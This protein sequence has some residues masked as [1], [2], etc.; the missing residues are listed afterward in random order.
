MAAL[1][2]MKSLTGQFALLKGKTE[3]PKNLIPSLCPFQKDTCGREFEL[4]HELAYANYLFIPSRSFFVNQLF[5]RIIL[6]R[7][8]SRY[9]CFPDTG[10]FGAFSSDALAASSSSVDSPD[11]T[12]CPSSDEKEE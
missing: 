7:T 11:L 12:F 3:K 2:V 4:R 1:P 8:P 10:F 9:S 5:E 6:L